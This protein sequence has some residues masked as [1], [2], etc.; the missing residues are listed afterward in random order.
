MS[1]TPYFGQQ[2]TSQHGNQP[3][4]GQ[5]PPPPSTHHQQQQHQGGQQQHPQSV[6]FGM[7]SGHDY[8]HTGAPAPPTMPQAQQP[9]Q[10]PSHFGVQSTQQNGKDPISYISHQSFLD[11]FTI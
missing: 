3:V 9:Q 6:P 5:H 11:I 1:A 2:P 4:F 10:P 8:S 7:G